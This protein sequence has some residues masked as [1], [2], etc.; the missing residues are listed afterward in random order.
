MADDNEVTSARRVLVEMRHNW[1]KNIATGYQRGQTEDAIKNLI[2]VQQA[3]EV[4][5][6]AI[7][8]FE[9]DEEEE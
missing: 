1:I 7:D 3:I 6:S 4:I 2:E 9:E 5:D 8:E